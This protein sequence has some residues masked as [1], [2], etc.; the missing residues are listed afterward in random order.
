MD[1]GLFLVTGNHPSLGGPVFPDG[2]GG[3]ED[4]L[5]VPKALTC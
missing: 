3:P 5:L 2:G 1:D 4:Y